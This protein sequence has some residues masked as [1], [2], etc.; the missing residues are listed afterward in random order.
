VYLDRARIAAELAERA[1]SPAEPLRAGSGGA[2]A[3]GLY[4]QSIHW[5]LLAHRE[6]GNDGVPSPRALVD[7]W[8]AYDQALLVRAADGPKRLARLRADLIHKSWVDF[9][10]LP[11]RRQHEVLAQ[12]RA[13]ALAL[14]SGFEP[15]RTIAERRWFRRILFATCG[16]LVLVAAALTARAARAALE[17][18]RDLAARARWT[19]SSQ[20]SVGGC[21]SP[22]QACSESPDYFFHTNQENDPWIVLDLGRVKQTSSIVVRNR[23]D[24]CAERAVP[25]VVELSPDN[26]HWTIVANRG[27]VFDTWR[28]SYAKTRARY[29][30]LHVPKPD[31]ILHLKS[32]RVL[33]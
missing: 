33:P 17:A 18:R 32:V 23:L 28:A 22:R 10:D 30:K 21:V 16:V 31:A 1:R 20:H 6:L 7:L 14:L 12:A 11:P 29:V 8:D 19:T 25:L 3:C 26:E 5:A 15:E 27:T 2:F 24:C 13:F 4:R 9:E